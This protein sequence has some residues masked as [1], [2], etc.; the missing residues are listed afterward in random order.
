VQDDLLAYVEYK[1]AR[2]N[3]PTGDLSIDQ[4]HKLRLWATWEAR[5]GK[6]G[7]L[8]IGALQRVS[9]G[10]PYSSGANINTTPYVTNPGYLTP[11]TTIT[12]Y[13]GGRGNFRTD[14]VSATD[15]SFNYQLPVGLLKGGHL[16]ARV[17][18]E[19]LFNQSAHD[20]S[21][22][23]TVFTASNQNPQRTL[24]AFNPFTEEP[25]E[26]V[27]YELGPSF[28]VPISADDYQTP[29]TLLFAVGFRF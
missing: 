10:Q 9:S 3:T 11:D 22:N 24:L 20:G 13:F 2:W 26:G 28:G 19:N 25:I 21:G 7:G 15:L 27:H 1:D 12:Y 4:R 6:A 23:E 17:I 16:F 14:T 8:S 18:V 5:L 29:R